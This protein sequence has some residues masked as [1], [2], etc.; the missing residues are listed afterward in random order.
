MGTLGQHFGRFTMIADSFR[1][2]LECVEEIQRLL[3]V[4]DTQGNQMNGMPFD[5]ARAEMKR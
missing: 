5:T 1:Q 4:R 3:V 2:M